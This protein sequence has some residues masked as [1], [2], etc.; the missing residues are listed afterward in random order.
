MCRD[1][2]LGTDLTSVLE[3]LRAAAAAA[4]STEL[5]V[6]LFSTGILLLS[7]SVGFLLKRTLTVNVV[8]LESYAQ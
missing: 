4:P 7:L 1:K 2:Y 6:V 3:V 8:A 5:P